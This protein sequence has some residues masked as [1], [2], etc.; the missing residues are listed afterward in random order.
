MKIGGT[1][2]DGGVVNGFE[3]L[4]SNPNET[5]VASVADTY[6]AASSSIGLSSASKIHYVKS[7]K[8]M[9][10][11]SIFVGFRF[12]SVFKYACGELKRRKEKAWTIIRKMQATKI[13]FR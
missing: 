1:E 7:W 6:V 9:V 2:G 13:Y 12:I 5:V 10:C 4:E 3:E 8:I 11:M